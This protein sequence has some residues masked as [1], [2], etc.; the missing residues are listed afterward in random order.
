MLGSVQILE[1]A[2]EHK[3]RTKFQRMTDRSYKG[4]YLVSCVRQYHYV[5]HQLLPAWDLMISFLKTEWKCL[6]LIL[7]VG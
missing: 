7:I 6:M 4:P 1:T 5:T 2:S 3:R